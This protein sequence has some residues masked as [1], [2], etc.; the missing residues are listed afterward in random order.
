LP[1]DFMTVKESLEAKELKPEDSEIAMLPS[2]QAELD[3]DTAVKVLRLIDRLED[4]DDTQNVYSNA[5]IPP[6]AYEQ[7]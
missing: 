6:E 3:V 7:L 2:T 4:L 5:E 1:E